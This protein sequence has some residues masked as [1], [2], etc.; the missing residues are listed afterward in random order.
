MNNRKAIAETE[1]WKVYQAARELG[2]TTEAKKD[3]AELCF[4]YNRSITV[5]YKSDQARIDSYDKSDNEQKVQPGVTMDGKLLRYYQYEIR[6][7]DDGSISYAIGNHSYHAQYQ[8]DRIQRLDYDG[9]GAT[10]ISIEDITDPTIKKFHEQIPQILAKND[11]LPEPK[12]AHGRCSKIGLFTC[13]AVT[14]AVTLTTAIGIDAYSRYGM[15][16]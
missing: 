1:G 12:S 9:W 6:I 4:N 5:V 7:K 13:A 11:A 16:K 3:L 15:N 14:V 8:D 2:F 10:S